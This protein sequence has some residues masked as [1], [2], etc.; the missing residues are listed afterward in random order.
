M[1]KNQNI[2]AGSC[3]LY[4]QSLII[5]RAE[6][7][8]CF[9]TSC[10]NNSFSLLYKPLSLRLLHLPCSH[11][12]VNCRGTD[13]TIVGRMNE[14]QSSSQL[15]VG[16][17]FFFYRICAY[18][19]F[20]CIVKLSLFHWLLCIHNQGHN[21]TRVSH[22]TFHPELLLP[23]LIY[24]DNPSDESEQR[25]Y[26]LVSPELSWWGRSRQ[27]WRNVW[28]QSA[29]PLVFPLWKHSALKTNYRE[30]EKVPE[31]PSQFTLWSVCRRVKALS[32]F[33]SAWNTCGAKCLGRGANK[34][35]SAVSSASWRS[36]ISFA[37]FSPLE[38]P[39]AEY[40]QPARLIPTETIATRDTFAGSAIHYTVIQTETMM[41]FQTVP[42]DHY[43]YYIHCSGG[44]L[45]PAARC[46][47]HTVSFKFRSTS[48]IIPSDVNRA[49]VWL[50]TAHT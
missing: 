16:T 5:L 15:L 17:L 10:R 8:F 39:C 26:T 44:F 33:Y 28:T 4:G 43:R 41:L 35:M 36:I 9:Q 40:W 50:W 37:A 32:S 48:W 31:L 24:K 2:S 21:S 13:S 18:Y 6:L 45:F 46:Y 49:P 30:D 42:L 47:F 29:E 34:I 14:E 38:L 3:V 23:A 19:V 7:S 22:F 25:A 11:L 1:K 27:V 20:L 12:A